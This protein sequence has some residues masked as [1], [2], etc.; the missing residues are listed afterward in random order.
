MKV[1]YEIPVIFRIQPEDEMQQAI[2]QVVAWIETKK[3]ERSPAARVEH[4][5]RA[6]S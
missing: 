2:D 3:A 5:G 1:Q 6:M 4:G